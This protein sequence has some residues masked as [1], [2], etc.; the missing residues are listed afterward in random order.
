MCVGSEAV[1]RR[2]E[3]LLE[4]HA[5][6]VRHLEPLDIPRKLEYMGLVRGRE[7]HD[8]RQGARLSSFKKTQQALGYKRQ[9][10]WP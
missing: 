9:S 6:E 1:G 4:E 2:K 7:D 5:L 10:P 3:L 8:T